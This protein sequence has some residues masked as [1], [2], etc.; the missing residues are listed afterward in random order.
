MAISNE[1]IA[2][3]VLAAIGGKDNITSVTNCMT[4]LR[5]Q[6]KD[7][8]IPK[9]D[10][11]KKIS[12]VLGVNIAGNEYQI[13]IGQNVPK[14]YSFICQQAGLKKESQIDEN[15]DAPKEKLTWKNAGNKILGYISGCMTPLIPAMMGAAM[16]KTL[17]V[18]LGPGMLNVIA[19]DS[20]FYQ[21]CEFVYNAFFYFLPIYLGFNAAKKVGMDPILGALA[22]GC[23][24][25]PGFTTLAS[26][27]GAS[28][29]VYGIPARMMTYGQT[30]LP[31]LLIV[32][33]MSIVNK[34][35]KKHIPDVLST[36][37]TPL[38]TMIVMVPLIYC[39]LGPLGG[40]LG[41]FI[42][43]GLIAFGGFGGFIAVAVVAAVWELLV[44]TGMHGV[45]IMFAI[46]TMM[47]TGSDF[48]VLVAGGIATWAAY[49]MALG[50]F[51]R[52][53]NKEE[54]S[55][56]L[57]YTVSGILGGVTEPVLY[58]IG[59]KYKKPF[60]ALIIG[61]FCGG[62]YAGLT[63]VGVYVM[64]SANFLAILGFV[65]GGTANLVNGI[66]GSL[67]AMGVTTAITYFTGFSKDDPA[68]Q[69][70]AE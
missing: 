12:G 48:F 26:T 38:L 70:T 35:F 59:F 2:K 55:L 69:K 41:D 18:L 37:F 33:V 47:S 28:F 21:L 51:L 49:G 31:I 62:L 16:F 25:V 40:Y 67:I 68:L 45:L 11:I 63:H 9:I 14:V 46:T 29:A 64:G 56:A 50:S 61:G 13:I 60:I 5:F 65:G 6:L 24:L 4:R 36:V 22:A 17:E 15:L 34:F 30:V 39:V 32:P 58:G 43:K 66:I 19:A 3:N 27:E 53:R 44:I 57:G 7:Q 20:N 54:K 42:G 10:E 8:S 52:F 23:L 1:E